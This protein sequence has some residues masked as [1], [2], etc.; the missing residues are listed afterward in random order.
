MIEEYHSCLMASPHINQDTKQDV[1]NSKITYLPVTNSGP[2]I[3]STGNSHARETAESG[4]QTMQ[5]VTHPSSLA[6]YCKCTHHV[7]VYLYEKLRD[8]EV[9]EIVIEMV[10]VMVE[11]GT[12]ISYNMTPS[13]TIEPKRSRIKRSR[14]IIRRGL[15]DL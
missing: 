7:I 6:L 15:T 11:R 10:M 1:S 5:P 8:C 2:T 9:R 12:I 14:D 4:L 3:A 13:R